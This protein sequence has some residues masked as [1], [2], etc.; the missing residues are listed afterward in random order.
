MLNASDIKLVVY[1]AGIAH[2]TTTEYRK[3]GPITKEYDR[4][5][6]M[7]K[8]AVELN[9][10]YNTIYKSVKKLERLGIFV[11]NKNNKSSEGKK[12]EKLYQD[13]R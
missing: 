2:G 6:S 4:F 13:I 11:D 10:S 7:E 1:V 12:S 9:L 5:W 3:N 8:L